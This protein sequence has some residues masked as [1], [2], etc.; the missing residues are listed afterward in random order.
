VKKVLARPQAGTGSHASTEPQGVSALSGFDPARSRQ[1]FGDERLHR[2]QRFVRDHD[3][4]LERLF[5]KW[6]ERRRRRRA[7]KRYGW[8]FCCSGC[9]R[10]VHA[11]ECAKMVAETTWHWHYLCECGALNH[12]FLGA[13]IATPDDGRWSGAEA[14]ENGPYLAGGKA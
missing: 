2:G 14:Y 6:A 10:W 12:I 3:T 1:V 7:F 8:D 4:F 13:I 5:P 11:E 9:G